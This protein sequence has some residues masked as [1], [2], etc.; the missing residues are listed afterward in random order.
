MH[1][2][3]ATCGV[4][5]LI[6]IPD[7]IN[8]EEEQVHSSG[9]CIR[10]G[11]SSTIACS[12]LRCIR[13]VWAAIAAT[14]ELRQRI[15]I[16]IFQGSVHHQDTKYENYILY[17]CWKLAQTRPARASVQLLLA[18]VDGQPWEHLMN[19]RVQHYGFKFDYKV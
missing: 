3:T 14:N 11:S 10:V 2:D 16:H 12:Q 4:P 8:V 6:L 9:V 18:S 19:R 13:L 5:G 17:I 1:L 15:L 7:F